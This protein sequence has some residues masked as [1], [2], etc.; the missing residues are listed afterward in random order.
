MYKTWLVIIIL[1]VGF[2]L[3]IGMAIFSASKNGDQAMTG[4]VLESPQRA[5]PTAVLLHP[6]ETPV[7]QDA[8]TSS[9]PKS[10]QS[11][12]QRIFLVVDS[13]KDGEVV[14]KETLVISGKTKAG[15]EVAIN[16]IELKAGSDGGFT[17]KIK[18]DE[19]QNYIVVV[20]NDD[21]GNSEEKELTVEY[22]LN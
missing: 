2:V 18:L 10:I 19:G 8:A 1:G 9:V 21:E 13:P 22:V 11:G 6:S 5:A 15:A 20:A 12:Q 16:E 17:T 7:M 4:Q 14:N 3:V